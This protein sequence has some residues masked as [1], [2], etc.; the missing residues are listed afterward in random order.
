MPI[1]RFGI[2]ARY[3]PIKDVW[4]GEI[5]SWNGKK[6][7][8]FQTSPIKTRVKALKLAIESIHNDFDRYLYQTKHP[9]RLRDEIP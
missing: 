5:T 2:S 7:R 8:R 1:Y 6:R 9:A 4:Q 3:L